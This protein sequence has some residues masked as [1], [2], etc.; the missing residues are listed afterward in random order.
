MG[1]FI[2]RFLFPFFFIL[3]DGLEMLY[4]SGTFLHCMWTQ[5]WWIMWLNNHNYCIQNSLDAEGKFLPK[6]SVKDDVQLCLSCWLNVFPL[7][8]DMPLGLTFKLKLS[9]QE[10]YFG[11]N[12]FAET[13]VTCDLLLDLAF[14]VVRF[15][16]KVWPEDKSNVEKVV[17]YEY[18]LRRICLFP[19]L[20]LI[21]VMTTRALS[22]RPFWNPNATSRMLLL[23][24]S[25]VRV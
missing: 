14:T 2:N 5:L 15:S 9:F 20:G 7:I 13:Q 10:M 4:P 22:S 1:F 21:L 17:Q 25:Q 8:W 23:P 3:P 24:N 16:L 19:K 11:T 18:F 12:F 6:S